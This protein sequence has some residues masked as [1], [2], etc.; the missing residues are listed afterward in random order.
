[1]TGI[2]LPFYFLLG[3]FFHI[4]CHRNEVS[5]VTSP[6]RFEN[7]IRAFCSVVSLSPANGVVSLALIR[8]ANAS[9]L[10]LIL[11]IRKSVQPIMA[12]FFFFFC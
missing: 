2:S 7:D 1:M 3:H 11:Q 5:G 9:L 6:E 12:D 10:A 4:C 8:G